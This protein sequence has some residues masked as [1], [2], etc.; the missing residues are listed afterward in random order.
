VWKSRR[1][2]ASSAFPRSAWVTVSSV[3]TKGSASCGV[4][5]LKDS[6]DVMECR[7][8]AA[9]VG[10]DPAV[11]ALTK[12]RLDGASKPSGPPPWNSRNV[13]RDGGTEG[14]VPER[15]ISDDVGETAVAVG[16]P[17]ARG[18]RKRNPRASPSVD[19]APR[20][21]GI[22]PSRRDRPHREQ[23]L[24]VFEA[25]EVASWRATA[26]A[27]GH[28]RNRTA[29]D[30]VIPSRKRASKRDF[31]PERHAGQEDELV[32]RVR[33]F[34]VARGVGLG[35]AGACASERTSR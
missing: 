24:A 33:A 35:V 17:P 1:P 20:R 3:M 26:R 15:A 18:R 32:A 22:D 6:V 4:R 13:R 28:R 29:G 5:R 14:R 27:G 21:A 10:D 16:S 31:L 19:A 12:R 23:E 25:P 34:D 9:D 30:A 11:A 2:M 8:D 7:Q